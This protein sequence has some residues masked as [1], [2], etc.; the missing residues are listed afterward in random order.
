MAGVH[1]AWVLNH[2]G[3]DSELFLNTAS[4]PRLILKVDQ[5]PFEVA[6]ECNGYGLISSS[7]LVALL[8]VTYRKVQ[9]FD[10]ALCLC[11][12]VFLGSLFNTLRILCII[13]LAPSVGSSYL[14]MHE[15]V[16][17]LFFWGCLV[18]VWFIIRGFPE[19]SSRIS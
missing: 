10:K 5:R 2:F 1:S 13:L 12:A 7:A 6:S 8:L 3:L 9:W 14:V 17:T 18:L 16:G 11:L 4:G 19:Q 15:T